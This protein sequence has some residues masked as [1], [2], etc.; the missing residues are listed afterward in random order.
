MIFKQLPLHSSQKQTLSVKNAMNSHLNLLKRQLK[1]TTIQ[2]GLEAFSITS[3][4]GLHKNTAG[5]GAIFTLHRVEPKIK[6]PFDPNGIL[7][8]TPDFLDRAI[9]TLHQKGYAALPLSQLPTYLA[10]PDPTRKIMCFGL[11]DGYYNNISHA[12]PVF[13]KHQ[14]PFTLFPCVGLIERTHSMW[15]ET[16]AHVVAQ[17]EQIDFEF[18]NVNISMRTVTPAQKYLAFDQLAQHMVSYEQFEAIDALSE[19]AVKN[20]IDPMQIVDDLIMDRDELKKLSTHPLAQIGAH[21]LSHPA[22]SKLSDADLQ[23]EISG[24]RGY[25]TDLIGYE[26]QTIAYPYGGSEHVSQS[27]CDAAREAGFAAAV[28]TRPNILSEKAQSQLHALPRIS[29]NGNYQKTNYVAALAS[30]AMFKFFK[31]G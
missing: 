8:V 13:E 27:V 24:S 5:L 1:K 11:D 23:T 31:A 17:V 25:L 21:T 4:L 15:W 29:L 14:V 19:F 3:D 10:N 16:L 18:C 6:T 20:G 30:G 9:Q 28:T 7:S 22:L 12:L 2:T 26:P